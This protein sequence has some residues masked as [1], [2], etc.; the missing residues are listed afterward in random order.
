MTN[1]ILPYLLIGMII[2]IV[3][4]AFISKIGSRKEIG[5]TAAFIV[6]L[7]LSPLLGLVIVLASED[8]KDGERKPAD[9]KSIAASVIALIALFVIIGASLQ[10]QP[11]FEFLAHSENIE[12]TQ[13]RDYGDVDTTATQVTESPNFPDKDIINSYRGQTFE[14]SDMGIV[15]QI[16]FGGSL[17]NPEIKYQADGGEVLDLRIGFDEFTPTVI[18][19]KNRPNVFYDLVNLY[20]TQF[21]LINPD[22]RSQVFRI[23]M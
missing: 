17:A 13:E 18:S 10:K 3:F 5:G 11:L 14:S 8:L 9:E 22:G 4:A 21:T 2:S 20:S 19:F 12:T 6:S 7:L 23:L 16:T 1:L 15:E